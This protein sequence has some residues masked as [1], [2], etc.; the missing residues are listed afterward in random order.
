MKNSNL[1][2]NL[3]LLPFP[4]GPSLQGGRGASSQGH[5]MWLESPLLSSPSALRSGQPPCTSHCS[6][7]ESFVFPQLCPRYAQL[8]WTALPFFIHLDSSLTFKIGLDISPVSVPS[9][10]N[11]T[12]GRLGG[13]K[14][15]VRN[16]T[17]KSTEEWSEGF[18]ALLS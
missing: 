16:N 10:L 12:I 4:P 7:S 17:V 13:S 18:P 8:F 2:L 3:R 5:G 9:S 11:F 1:D 6:D 14:E 15:E